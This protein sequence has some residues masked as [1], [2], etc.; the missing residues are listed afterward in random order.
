MA[1]PHAARAISGTKRLALV[2]RILNA[3]ISAHPPRLNRV[4]EKFHNWRALPKVLHIA[5]R[6]RGL[7][8]IAPQ[9]AQLSHRRLNVSEFVRAARLDQRLSPVPIPGQAKSRECFSEHGLLKLRVF[10]RA[11]AVGADF[12]PADRASA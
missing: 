7:P 10:P 3:P 6:Y 5:I 4:G 8:L 12:H 1:T 9:F 11:P 2:K